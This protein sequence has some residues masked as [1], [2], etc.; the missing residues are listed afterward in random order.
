MA[1]MCARS[2]CWR[3]P[4]LPFRAQEADQAEVSIFVVAVEL[5]EASVR[6]DRDEVVTSRAGEFDDPM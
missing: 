3:T 2:A 1:A 4:R 6:L 5:D